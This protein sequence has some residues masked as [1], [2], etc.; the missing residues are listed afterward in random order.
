MTSS[1]TYTD[2]A[3]RHDFVLLFDVADGNPNGDPDAGN[4][5]RVDPETMQGL[6]TDVAIKRKVRDYVD[7]A[8]GRET[9]FKIY[10]QHGAF[11]GD[12]RARA[13]TEHFAG[14]KA[15]VEDGRRAMCAD[16][17]DVRMFGAVMAMKE[18]NAGQV[19]GPV[20]LTFARSIDAIV[21]LDHSI[22]GPAQNEKDVN[23]SDSEAQATNYGT[24][25]RKSNVPYGLYRAQ[26]FF[27]PHFAAQTGANED[28]LALLWHALQS[29]WDLDRSSARGL[30]AC[31]GLYVFTHDSALGNAPAHKLFDLVSVKKVDGVEAPRTFHDYEVTV[32]E[33]GIPAGVT[34]TRLEG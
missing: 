28:D 12:T 22:V 31:R 14:G 18:N 21:P 30:I 20:Q 11:L 16:F 6:V 2:P 1:V 13:F 25:G 8:R 24:M 29:M 5:P 3:R 33:G 4:L 23:R 10:V 9:R 19:R 26:G 27:N 34:L 7:V 17:F 15:S 32:D